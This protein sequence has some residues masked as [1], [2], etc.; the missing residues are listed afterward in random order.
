[1]AKQDEIVEA[2]SNNIGS[3]I[4]DSAHKW[5]AHTAILCPHGAPGKQR[6]T[7]AELDKLSDS[8]AWKLRKG[9]VKKGVKLLML[10]RPGIDFI[11][12]AF[13][14]FKTGAA[15]VLIDPGMGIKKLLECIRETGPEAMLA[16]PAAHWLRLFRPKFFESIT[17]AFAI[18]GLTPLGVLKLARSST[19]TSAFPIAEVLPHDMAAILFTTGS[20]GPPKGVVYT[21][22]IF[23]AQTA[24]IARE[25]GAGPEEIDMPGFPLFALFSAALGMGCVIPDM[26]PAHP[27]NANPEKI[28]RTLREHKVSFS[29]GSPALWKRVATY[30]NERKLRVPSLKKVLMAGAPVSAELHHSVKQMMAGDG[31]TIVPYGATESLPL[32]TFR[33]SKM[34]AETAGLTSAGKGYCVGY[35]IPELTVKIIAISDEEIPEW[36]ENLVLPDGEIGEITV[37]GPIVTPSYYKNPDA[38]RLAKIKDADSTFWHRMGDLGYLDAKGRLWFCGRKSHRVITKERTLYSVCCETIFNAHPQVARSALVGLGTGE[39]CRPAIIIEPRSGNFPKKAGDKEKFIT[40]LREL[41]SHTEFT[42]E[43]DIF[44]FHPSFPVD[45]RHNAKISRE[46]LRDWAG[47][48]KA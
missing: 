1:M 15:P 9:G 35:H 31:D 5:P 46:K 45:V 27:A 30:C 3:L 37:K 4:R 32:A 41:G 43:I 20:T 36:D 17:H 48:Q 26:D 16:V 8:Y 23:R 34:L 2:A 47:T 14:V 13:A 10:Q 19:K 38:T 33:G 21:H 42:R 11:A 6:I 44:L 29:F 12:A 7:F 18:S 22:D 24:I 39:E 40:E 25:Y 28:F